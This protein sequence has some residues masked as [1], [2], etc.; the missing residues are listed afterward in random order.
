LAVET[1]RGHGSSHVFP[2]GFESGNADGW[3]ATEAGGFFTAPMGMLWAPGHGCVYAVPWPRAVTAETPWRLRLWVRREPN[4]YL[5]LINQRLGRELF[6]PRGDHSVTSAVVRP[7]RLR[8][9]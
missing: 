7:I 9:K 3:H 6:G 5:T 1:Q 4:I 2:A 8:S